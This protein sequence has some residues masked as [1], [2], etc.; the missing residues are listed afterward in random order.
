MFLSQ[1]VKL[2]EGWEPLLRTAVT[3]LYKRFSKT[4]LLN[5]YLFV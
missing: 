1:E 3:F 5:A 2:I 4:H